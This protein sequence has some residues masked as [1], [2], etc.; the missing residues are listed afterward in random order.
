MSQAVKELGPFVEILEDELSGGVVYEEQF[1]AENYDICKTCLVIIYRKVKET[2]YLPIEQYEL[3]RMPIPSALKWSLNNAA[4][5]NGNE[6]GKAILAYIVA[7]KAVAT[8]MLYGRIVT[9]TEAQLVLDGMK[10]SVRLFNKDFPYERDF[11]SSDEDAQPDG[12]GEASAGAKRSR[13][14]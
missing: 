12:A 4:D 1:T 10:A 5:E 7:L 6:A 13:G 14:V 2:L 11:V 8:S 3:D 9:S